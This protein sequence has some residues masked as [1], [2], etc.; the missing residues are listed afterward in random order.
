[1]AGKS[2]PFFK[3]EKDHVIFTGNYMEVYIPRFYFDNEISRFLGDKVETLGVFNFKVFSSD[4]KKD[5]AELHTFKFPSFLITKPTSSE[6]EELED[7][8]EESDENS[9]AV[10]KYYKGDIFIDNVNV[11]QKSD[12]TILFIGLLHS[13]KL[14]N[15]IPYDEVLQLELENTAFNGVNLNVSSTVLELI[16]SEIYRDKNDLSKSFRFKAGSAGKVSMHDY[17]PINIKQISTFNST[18][19]GVTFEDIDYNLVASVNKTRYNKKESE[20]PIEKTIKY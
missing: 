1:M 11:Q 12:N 10:L 7:L 17:R 3:E 5:K 14:P 20:S 15:S 2:F 16:I 9:F 13:G 4:T 8:I 6:Y 18:F 19:T